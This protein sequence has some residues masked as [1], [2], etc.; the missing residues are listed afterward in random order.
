ML[1]GLTPFSEAEDVMPAQETGKQRATR[2]PLDYY[3]KPNLL[4]RW[5]TGLALA[6]LVVTCGWLAAGLLGSDQ[7]RV[8]YSRGPVASVHAAW[9]DNC[10][11]CH[12]PFAHISGNFWTSGEEASENCK[13]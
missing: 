1:G 12:A 8:R 11:A 6:A 5:K 2:I 4:E 9:E 7:G 13:K 10:T 3:K